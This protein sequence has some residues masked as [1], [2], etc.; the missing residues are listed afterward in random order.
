MANAI[1]LGQRTLSGAAV[2]DQGPL[3]RD[4]AKRLESGRDAYWDAG[5]G[6]ALIRCT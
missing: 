3:R 5:S 1:Q 4:A 6:F 2:T